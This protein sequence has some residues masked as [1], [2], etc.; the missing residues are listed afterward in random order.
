MLRGSSRCVRGSD[1]ENE[2]VFFSS[3]QAVFFF[4][5]VFSHRI[6]FGHLKD[7]VPV[8]IWFRGGCAKKNPIELRYSQ[9][10]CWVE[11]PKVLRAPA[12]R[13]KAC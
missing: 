5:V 8:A 6:F 7:D 9:A 12:S 1:I 10:Q 13:A 11:V 4:N 2:Y 3:V